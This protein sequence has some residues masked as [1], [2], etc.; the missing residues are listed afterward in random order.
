VNGPGTAA[1]TRATFSARAFAVY[2][3]AMAA[4]L[5]CAPNLLLAAFGVP[6]TTEVWI[7]VAGVLAC[8][9]GVYAWVGAAHR[10]FLQASVYTRATV[11][12]ALTA[13]VLLGLGSP[14]LALFGAIDLCGGLWT[15]CALRADDRAGL[16]ALA[17]R[18]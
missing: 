4:V 16:P 15:Y 10:P 3:F 12:V 2:V 13:F 8:M 7:R 17:A 1:L 11:F 18:S 5:V 14:M 9:I 6:P